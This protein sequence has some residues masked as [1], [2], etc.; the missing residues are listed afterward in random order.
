[1]EKNND[2]KEPVGEPGQAQ[3]WREWWPPSETSV[4][5]MTEEQR[6]AQ[7]WVDWKPDPQQPNA[8]PWLQ[9]VPRD[10]HVVDQRPLKKTSALGS[11][12]E[13]SKPA[14]KPDVSTVPHP[15]HMPASSNA[16][17]G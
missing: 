13:S 6:R 14:P 8:K 10:A 16:E 4:K 12:S 17:G 9:W 7:P 11:A 15:V 1:M 5:N 2:I 3:P